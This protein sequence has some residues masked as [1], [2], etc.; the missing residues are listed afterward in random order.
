MHAK[1]GPIETTQHKRSV[2]SLGEHSTNKIDK[3]SREFEVSSKNRIAHKQSGQSD[4]ANISTSW[5]Q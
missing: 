5:H 2:V 1:H 3:P 4:F